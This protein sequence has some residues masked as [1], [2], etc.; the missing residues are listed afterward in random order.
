MLYL[1]SGTSMERILPLNW[2]AT[3]SVQVKRQ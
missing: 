1:T 2:Q 3:V